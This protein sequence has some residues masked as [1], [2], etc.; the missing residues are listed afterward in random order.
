MNEKGYFV[1]DSIK[2]KNYHII[3]IVVS[4]G[5]TGHTYHCSS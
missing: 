2:K 3:M 5:F 1:S 4:N